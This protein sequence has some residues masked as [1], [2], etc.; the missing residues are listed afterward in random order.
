MLNESFPTDSIQVAVK[1]EIG[2]IRVRGRGTFKVSTSIK[3]FGNAQLEAGTHALVFD[4]EDCVGMDSTFMGVLAGLCTRFRRVTDGKVVML[5]VSEKLRK[6]M[7]TLGLNRLVE[8][9]AIQATPAIYEN[10]LAGKG[11]GLQNLDQQ[12]ETDLKAAETMLE[13]HENLVGIDE[14]NL[15]RFKD[16]LEYLR[17]DIQ[18][19]R[20]T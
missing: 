1:D 14:R 13:A 9:H 5:N 19:R 17:E 11:S 12:A 18:N 6:L 2:F 20:T 4:L 10:C 8:I 16:V 15:P 3:E 7:S